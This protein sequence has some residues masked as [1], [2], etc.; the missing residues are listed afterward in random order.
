MLVCK[1]WLHTDVHCGL[2]VPVSFCLHGLL[3]DLHQGMLIPTSSCLCTYVFSAVHHDPFTSSCREEREKVCECVCVCVCVCDRESVCV[4]VCDRESKCVCMCVWQREREREKVCVC[5]C[6]TESVCVCVCVHVCAYVRVCVC[7]CVCVTEK[8]KRETEGWVD[9]EE[10]NTAAGLSNGHHLHLT[11]PNHFT[12]HCTTDTLQQ[13]WPRAQAVKEEKEGGGGGR[14]EGREG[15]EERKDQ[16]GSEGPQWCKQPVPKWSRLGLWRMACYYNMN[17]HHIHTSINM[18][19]NH[20]YQHKQVVHI[21]HLTRDLC[22]LY[23]QLHVNNMSVKCKL[24]QRNDGQMWKWAVARW[25]HLHVHE[26][27]IP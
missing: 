13:A 17:T 6:V 11:Q 19:S 26:A 14:G 9:V 23:T 27:A 21:C 4:C 10:V 16:G 12:P 1:Q 20:N 8:V 15:R 25:H 5:V 18:V 24:S 7:V 2:L 22:Q 3:L